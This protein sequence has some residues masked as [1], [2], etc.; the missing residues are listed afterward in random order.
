MYVHTIRGKHYKTHYY[1]T[2]ACSKPSAVVSSCEGTVYL[3]KQSSVHG[4]F[5]DNKI[6]CDDK[7]MC[8]GDSLDVVEFSACK[9]ISEISV[10][11]HDFDF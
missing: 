4:I 2:T 1:S 9:C 10:T 11:G 3:I 6:S 5:I 7:P 8:G